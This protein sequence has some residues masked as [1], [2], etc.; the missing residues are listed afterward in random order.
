MLKNLFQKIYPK[1]LFQENHPKNCIPKKSTDLA[2]NAMD[3]KEE[4]ATFRNRAFA[5]T[6]R[7]TIL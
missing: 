6:K 2:N 3:L 5:F 7:I 4:Y 1:I